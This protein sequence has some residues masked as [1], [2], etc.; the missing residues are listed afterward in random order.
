MKRVISLLMVFA[1]LCVCT[2]AAAET[3]VTSFYPIWLLT[4][5]LTKGIDGI[6]V[7]NLASPDTGCLHDYQLQTGDMKAL[8]K[9]DVF[10]VN[11]AGMESYLE[12]VFEAFPELTV[13]TAA[14]GIP[15]VENVTGLVIGNAETADEDA[16][17]AEVNAHIWLDAGNAAVMAANLAKGLADA[18]PQYAEQISANL[19]EY[20]LR[21]EQLDNELREGLKDLQSRDIITFHEAFPYFARAYGLNVAAVVN[22]EPGETLT[23]TQLKQLIVT[24]RELGVPPLFA[25]PQYEDLS[26]R[27]LAAETGAV[28]YSLDPVVTGP[29]TDVPYDYYE[30]VMRENMRV[31]REALG[32]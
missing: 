23:P 4:L 8:A 10:L 1:V 30:T 13:I 25:E 5:N 19:E 12:N 22:R 3:A 24:V 18:F 7:E 11:G 16:D 26:A 14:D 21:L 27:T 31:L 15:L 32:E 20:T 2:A 29:E 6:T 28:I 17:E 9:A